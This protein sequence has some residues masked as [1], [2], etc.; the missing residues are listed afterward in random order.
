MHCSTSR[1][2]CSTGCGIC[3]GERLAGCSFLGRVRSCLQD[4]PGRSPQD[5]RQVTAGVPGMQLTAWDWRQRPPLQPNIRQSYCCRGELGHGTSHDAGRFDQGRWG[6]GARCFTHALTRADSRLS[7]TSCAQSLNH[8]LTHNHTHTIQIRTHI[9][10]PDT[11]THTQSRYAHTYT[12]QMR[13]V[14]PWPG[15][16]WVRGP[17]V[18][19]GG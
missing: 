13:T 8:S 6:V 7:I 1:S 16:D 15:H 12:V 10:N 17:A 11:H 19:D 18:Q 2:R 4:G 5:G 14:C 9:H 3:A